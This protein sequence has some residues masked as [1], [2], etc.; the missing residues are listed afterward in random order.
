[1]LS[2]WFLAI[3]FFWQILLGREGEA[4][5][6]CPALPGLVR[7]HRGTGFRTN[8]PS[9]S[10]APGG[11][12]P[13]ASP[14]ALPAAPPH[15]TRTRRCPSPEGRVPQ[16]TAAMQP[17]SAQLQQFCW[18]T[19]THGQIYQNTI[20]VAAAEMHSLH[21]TVLGPMQRREGMAHFRRIIYFL[22]SNKHY[23]LI[24]RNRVILCNNKTQQKLIIK[25]TP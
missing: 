6:R 9:P 21:G 8:R 4:P 12:T 11:G 24:Q 15:R 2:I 17:S 25:T 18:R 3:T 19:K 10:V 7:F 23:D 16:L 13:P 22:L 20:A 1:M 5:S 14:G